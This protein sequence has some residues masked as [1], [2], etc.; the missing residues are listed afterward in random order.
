MKGD[1][2]IRSESVKANIMLSCPQLVLISVSLSSASR[3]VLPQSNPPLSSKQIIERLQQENLRRSED[4]K[5]FTCTRSYR[6]E[7]HGIG[8][9][10]ADM[11]VEAHYDSPSTKTF[12][13][14]SEHGSKVLREKALRK[15]LE[16]EQEA[17][18]PAALRATA[19]SPENYVFQF[20]GEGA[21]AGR[22]S[23][24]FAVEPRHPNKFLYRGSIWIDAADFAVSQIE[25]EPSKNP[26]FWI[27]HTTIHH[28][29]GKVGD[30][31]LP[32]GNRSTSTMKIGGTATLTI[33]YTRYDVSTK[34]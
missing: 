10:S 28:A 5:H 4:L 32:V 11:V 25:A 22:P 12:R 34:P 24:E 33:D 23:Y 15:L 18:T 1:S 2:R 6:L 26:S 8:A 20:K 17:V 30:F 19:L 16:A 31:W 3:T 29:Y 14:V 27:R 7:Y 9:L 21:V 13:V